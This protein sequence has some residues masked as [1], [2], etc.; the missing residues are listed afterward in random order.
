[1]E[2]KTLFEQAVSD[3]R[4]PSVK[5]SKDTSLQLYSLYKQATE[6][7]IDDNGFPAESLDFIEKAK[8]EAWHSLRGISQDDAMQK[9]INMI[10]KLKE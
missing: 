8:H 3:S 10:N 7:D 4:S 5:P 2:L 1:M 6:G 9:Y